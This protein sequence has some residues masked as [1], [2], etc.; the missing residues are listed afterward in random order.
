MVA[1]KY[2]WEDDFAV[3]TYFNAGLISLQT[4]YC[5]GKTKKYF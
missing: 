1:M 4:W 3:S 2:R 5:F